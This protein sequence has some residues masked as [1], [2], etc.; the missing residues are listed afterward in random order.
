MAVAIKHNLDDDVDN[1]KIAIEHLLSIKKDDL[2][3]DPNPS[4]LYYGANSSFKPKNI[5]GKPEDR[6]RDNGLKELHEIYDKL[7]LDTI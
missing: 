6:T 7:S 5:D 4:K 2:T 3:S 1:L